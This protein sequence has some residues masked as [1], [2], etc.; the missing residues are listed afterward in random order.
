MLLE[1]IKSLSIVF[2]ASALFLSC[3]RINDL[4]E[5]LAEAQQNALK[6]S[7]RLNN[8]ISD[9]EENYKNEQENAKTVISNLRERVANGVR[10]SKD[11][12][13]SASARSKDREDECRLSSE[14]ANEL[15]SIAE[16]G[17]E[18]IRKLNQCIDSYNAIREKQVKEWK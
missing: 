13:V 3:N 8:K 12:D 18:A 4:K 2:L 1:N 15:V 14:T 11:R 17:D 6:E 10:I 16:K 5:D 7:I 9:I